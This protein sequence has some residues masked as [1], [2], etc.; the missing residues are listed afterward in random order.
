MAIETL[1]KQPA[2]SRLYAFDFSAL[3]AVNED[4]ATVDSVT[5]DV[6]GLT[7]SGSPTIVGPLAQQ[8]ILGGTA[9]IRYKI[10]IRVTTNQSNILEGEGI[11]QVKDL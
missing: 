1:I 7:F 3:L 2:E 11:L 8:R 4:L 9:G 5:A 10:T 6:A